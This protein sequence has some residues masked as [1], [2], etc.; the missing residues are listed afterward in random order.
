MDYQEEDS[1]W[2]ENSKIFDKKKF[3]ARNKAT[4]YRRADQRQ[5]N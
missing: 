1:G 2:L 5:M 4:D 3:K